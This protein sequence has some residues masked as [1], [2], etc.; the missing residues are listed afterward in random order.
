MAHS[1]TNFFIA[2]TITKTN[3]HR[4]SRI[5]SSKINENNSYFNYG[6]TLF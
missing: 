2:D 6:K 4:D 1:L 3:V 5:L